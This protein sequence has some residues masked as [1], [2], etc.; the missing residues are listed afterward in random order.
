MET[1]SFNLLMT[2]LFIGLV[3]GHRFLS[4]ISTE[5]KSLGYRL[6]RIEHSFIVSGGRVRPEAIAISEDRQHTLLNEWTALREPEGSNKKDQLQ[7]YLQT[8]RQNLVNEG[9]SVEAATSNSTWLVVSPEALEAFKAICNSL[10]LNKLMLC[11][12]NLNVSEGYCVSYY[13]GELEDAKLSEVLKRGITAKR[14][15]TQFMPFLPTDLKGKD[16]GKE[17]SR[18]V[19]SFIVKKQYEFS[20]EDICS[21]IFGSWKFISGEQK[22]SAKRA[23][24]DVLNKLV[25]QNSFKRYLK[26]VKENPALW[27][28]IPPENRDTAQFA[29]T[30]KKPIEQFLAECYGDAYQMELFIDIDPTAPTQLFE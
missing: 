25:Q 29:R 17:V 1:L 28:I 27:Q 23:T 10:M 19:V 3:R 20:A 7:R 26:R 16:Y 11:S 9:I 13:C 21:K 4:P 30:L 12:F 24:K 14:I 15:P 2:N 8:T 5:V 22:A 6:F 18:Q